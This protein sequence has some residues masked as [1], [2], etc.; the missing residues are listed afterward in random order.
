M[1]NVDG[2]VYR[3]IQEQVK[4]NQEDIES[5]EEKIANHETV[6]GNLQ[7][8]I[9]T[10]IPLSQKATANGVAT[11]DENGKIPYEQI[12]SELVNCKVFTRR[13]YGSSNTGD[14][15]IDGVKREDIV[16]NIGTDNG[17]KVKNDFDELPFFSEIKKVSLR[18]KDSNGNDLSDTNG[19]A[20]YDD[21]V[22][23]PNYWVKVENGTDSNGDEY[24]DFSI[25]TEE[26]TGYTRMKINDDGSIPSHIGIGAYQATYTQRSDNSLMY[27]C[28]KGQPVCVNNSVNDFRDGFRYCIDYSH[29]ID[30]LTQI[31]SCSTS[32]YDLVIIAMI[33]EFGNRNAQ[34]LFG[35]YLRGTYTGYSYLDTTFKGYQSTEVC[36]Y[37]I[38]P[39]EKWNT[40]VKNGVAVGGFISFY[41][42]TASDGE[43]TSNEYWAKMTIQSVDE[44]IVNEEVVG[45]KVSFD[46]TFL[47]SRIN[48]IGEYIAEEV[49][50][51]ENI[52]SSSG[53]KS[54]RNFG[55]RIFTYRGIENLWGGVSTLTNHLFLKC[56]YDE[57]SGTKTRVKCDIVKSDGTSTTSNWQIYQA[58]VLSFLNGTTS[59]VQQNFIKKYSFKKGM[60]IPEELQSNGSI[61]Y[62]AKFGIYTMN[63]EYLN[64]QKGGSW[65][66]GDNNW[67]LFY[68]LINTW[69]GSNDSLT[70]RPLLC[71]TAL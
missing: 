39:K 30:T 26:K 49:G 55:L 27:G 41:S 9:D 59:A 53:Y 10:K 58:N 13:F 44:Y 65:Y 20:I 64:I 7:I 50:T 6:I 12:P 31:D 35:G 62:N 28:Q 70:V 23:L 56:T 14:L 67:G 24:T 21:F 46:K 43:R 51:T 54:N 32:D 66:N 71:K 8:D 63:S 5:C 45:Y 22:F 57:S 52:N 36:N 40:F 29:G 3:N 15:Y 69:S 68:Y 47:P 48:M 18:A 37:F 60:L 38:F 11:L 33:I 25:S 2:K 19:N 4:K 16:A 42:Y 1:I 34:S 61:Y 17:I